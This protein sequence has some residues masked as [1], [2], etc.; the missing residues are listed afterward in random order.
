MT[1]NYV[2]ADFEL[3]SGTYYSPA[4]KTGKKDD[5]MTIAPILTVAGSVS[6]QASIEGT[7]WYD[8][9]DTAITCSPG[10]L[11]QY[12]EAQEDLLYRIKSTTQFAS[13]KILI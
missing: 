4:F 6:L 9:E 8:I 7:N 13:A 12:K 10:G 11:Q 2:Q 5:L 1:I 3:D